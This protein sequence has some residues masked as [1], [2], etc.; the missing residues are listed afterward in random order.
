MCQE[1]AYSPLGCEPP[2]TSTAAELFRTYD[3]TLRRLADQFAPERI[4]KC[5]L[6]PLCLVR[7]WV[8]CSSSWMSSSRATVPTPSWRR[9]QSCLCSRV[10]KEARCLWSE[11][12]AVLIGPCSERRQRTGEAVAVNVDTAPAGQAN[13]WRHHADEQR[14]G[15]V[16]AL[17]RRQ[18]EDRSCIYWWSTTAY[19]YS[20]NCW[21]AV[22][23][24]PCSAAKVH[25]LIMQSATD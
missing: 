18:G 6:R 14:P 15:R 21:I 23:F 20:S 5:R 17:L 10:Q 11:E 12:E 19:G 7:R 22:R 2:S 3:D 24:S 4:V 1:I 16:L 25:K 13:C 9:Q 8:P